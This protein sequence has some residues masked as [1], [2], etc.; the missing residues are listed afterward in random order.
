[1]Q[2]AVRAED[3][4]GRFGG[5]EFLVLAPVRDPD[6]AHALALHMLAAVRGVV[7]SGPLVGVVSAS[8]GYAL[9]PGD[10]R[11]P[12]NLLQLADDAMYA[13]KREGKNRAL[14]CSAIT[15]EATRW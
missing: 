3:A 10:A 11:H 2:G 15:F 5:D 7:G 13:A 4:V 12:L 6:G 8:I 14:H 9:A 1:L